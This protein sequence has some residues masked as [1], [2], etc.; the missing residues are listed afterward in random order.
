LPLPLGVTWDSVRTP[1]FSTVTQNPVSGARPVSFS[2]S[3]FP[4]WAFE[5]HWDILRDQGLWPE[6]ESQPPGV[7]S[8][9]LLKPDFFALSD[10]FLAM[11]GSAGRFVYDPAA[12][13]IPLEDTYVTEV[14]AGTL[15]NG[16]SG[17]TN[18]VQTVFQLY[19]TSKITGALIPVEAIDAPSAISSAEGSNP[20]ALYLNG[21]LVSPTLYTLSQYPLQ[22]TFATAPS[23]GQA[24]SWS[25]NFAYVAKF[26][27]DSIDL[28]QFMQNLWELQSLKLEAVPLGF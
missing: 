17:T 15:V 8:S 6:G 27:D 11:N 7:N 28:N 18:G 23:T 1:R 21:S 9:S 3:P 13:V 2:V 20:F 12:N 16:Y 22:V 19:R 26:A 24:L 25:G 5:L 4:S 14:T 10:F